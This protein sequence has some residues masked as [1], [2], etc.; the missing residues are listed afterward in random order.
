MAIHPIQ[1]FNAM[2]TKKKA[3]VIGGA[4][5]AAA[6]VASGALAY[7]KGKSAIPETIEN[8]KTLQRT[9]IALKEGYKKLAGSVVETF[10]SIP[11]KV[12]NAFHKAENVEKA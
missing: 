1:A 2:P 9:G 8:S 5:V 3:A 11:A 10:K 6:V 7:S 12:S 4:A